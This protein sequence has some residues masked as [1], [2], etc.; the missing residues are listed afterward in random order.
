MCCYVLPIIALN[1]P[2]GVMC[3]YCEWGIGCKVWRNGKPAECEKFKCMYAQIEKCSINLRPDK[4]NIIFEKL[5]DNIIYG[6]MH[7]DHNDS[8]QTKNMEG[9]IKSFLNENFSVVIGS[10]TLDAPIIINKKG[11]SSLDVWKSLQKQIDMFHGFYN[12]MR[13]INDSTGLHNRLN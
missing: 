6:T 10:Y 8:Y 4:C 9:Q 2:P 12:I 5:Q 13:K 11:R 1:K 3:K 7:P